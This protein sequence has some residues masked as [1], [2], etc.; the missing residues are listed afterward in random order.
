MRDGV[1]TGETDPAVLE[2][3]AADNRLIRRVRWQLVAWSGFST[4]LVLVILGAA[5]YLIAAQTLATQDIRRLEARADDVRSFLAR[6]RPDPGGPELGFSFGGQ[7]SGT[8]AVIAD[9]AGRLL[10]TLDGRPQPGMPIATAID[11]A[12]STGVD[13]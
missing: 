12:R 7:A 13:I 8:F 4:L 2:A 11:G 9:D 6:E 5:L 10:G 1:G 3:I